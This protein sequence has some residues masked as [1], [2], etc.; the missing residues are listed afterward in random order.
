MSKKIEESLIDDVVRTLQQLD[1]YD[2]C[3]FLKKKYNIK[4]FD[5]SN[6]S[7]ILETKE[8]I[9]NLKDFFIEMKDNE[10]LNY[11]TEI[12]LFDSS[13]YEGINDR[14]IPELEE[15]Y[16]DKIKDRMR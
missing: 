13:T 8:G 4:D 10:Q 1:N 12:M 11:L 15:L 2:F 6:I 7:K 16:K 5:Y 14:L 3:F 9:N